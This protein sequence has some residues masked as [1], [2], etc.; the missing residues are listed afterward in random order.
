MN[1]NAMNHPLT[2]A[3]LLDGPPADFA[4]EVR[5]AASLGFAHVDVVALEER[6]TA[7]LEALADGDVMVR[8]AA[9]GR[10]LPDFCAPDV[11]DVGLRR[12]ALEQMRRQVADAARLGATHAY[13]VSGADDSAA[14]LTRFAETCSLLADYAA[15]RM[16]R[17]C[18]EP[19]P[20]RALPSAAA[21]LAWLAKT[22]HN[23]LAL[24]L[25]VGHCPLS[26]EEAA[27]VARAAAPRLG[28]VHLDDND[29]VSDLHW[30]LL[31]GR[32]TETHLTALE[33]ALRE[34]AFT[35]GISLELKTSAAERAPALRAS[36]EIAE[37]LFPQR[38]GVR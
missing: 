10:G 21:V 11:A 24:L 12:D 9:V 5:L 19:V 32:L 13:V 28:Y 3:V 29:G 25:D 30:P 33:A 34:T 35:G 16:V 2:L 17:L 36:K 15:G 18:V 27:A 26:G 31:T 38:R 23:N 6:P 20:G 4:A 8:C 7:D 1:G 22:G 37:R 14:G